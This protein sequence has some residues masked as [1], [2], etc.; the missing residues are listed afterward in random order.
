MK[1]RSP[2][3][4]IT[5]GRTFQIE[6]PI[7]EKRPS[8]IRYGRYTISPRLNTSNE[9][10]RNGIQMRRINPNPPRKNMVRAKCPNTGRKRKIAPAEDSPLLSVIKPAMINIMIRV[11]QQY[12]IKGHGAADIPRDFLYP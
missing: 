1:T 5:Y 7:R 11:K 10:S 4:V 8:S 9:T 2:I 3:P 12:P 6:K